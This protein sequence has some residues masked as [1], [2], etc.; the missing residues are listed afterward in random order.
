MGSANLYSNL[1]AICA[2]FYDLS[3]DAREVA[4][5]VDAKI[6]GSKP[7]K[8]LFVGGFFS[9]ARELIGK[10][11]SITVADYTDEMVEEGKKRLPG[12]KIVKADI[13][14]LPFENEFD[15]V[16]V[17]GRVFTHMYSDEDAGKALGSIKKSLKPKGILLFDNY[18]DTKITNTDYFNGRITVKDR[19]IEITRDSSTEIISKTPFIVNWKATYTVTENGTVQKFSD[20][21]EHRA[22]SRDEIKRTLEKNGFKQ[23]SNGNNFDSTS[24][25][26]IARIS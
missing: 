8:I 10:G 22:F 4:D 5:F 20:E 26:S 11:Y 15:A 1:A 6:S 16:L 9:V 25:Y 23:I 13:R 18:E 19:G 21:M 14:N 12:A 7:K 2:R 3:V 17:I 24:F